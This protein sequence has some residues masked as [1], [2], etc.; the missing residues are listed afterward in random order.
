MRKAYSYI[1]TH[2]GCPDTRDEPDYCDPCPRCN[3][4]MECV[5]VDHAAM[6]RELDAQFIRHRDRVYQ[7]SK[8]DGLS[9]EAARMVSLSA[10]GENGMFW[11]SGTDRDILCRGITECK[12]CKKP[13]P[14]KVFYDRAPFCSEECATEDIDAYADFLL[15]HQG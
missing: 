10:I 11:V 12:Y 14:E 5:G 3:S 7:L 8:I 13:L 2:C 1:C 6:D 15:E 9:D 4:R